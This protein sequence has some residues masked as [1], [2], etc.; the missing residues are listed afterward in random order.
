MYTDNNI[1]YKNKYLKY[2]NKYLE[3]KYNNNMKGER[4]I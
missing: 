4:V 3:T 2:K 1:N